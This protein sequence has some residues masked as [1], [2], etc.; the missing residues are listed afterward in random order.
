MEKLPILVNVDKAVPPKKM[1]KL[2][3]KLIRNGVKDHVIINNMSATYE[4]QTFSIEDL[5]MENMDL[6]RKSIELH[7]L[8]EENKVNKHDKNKK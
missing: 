1:R 2:K 6:I 3:E 8:K 5:I 4:Q 7:K